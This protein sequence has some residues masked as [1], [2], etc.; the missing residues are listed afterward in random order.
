MFF[1]FTFPCNQKDLKMYR[2]AFV[3]NFHEA[4]PCGN[5]VVE[6]V[7]EAGNGWRNLR[8]LRQQ[9][10]VKITQNLCKRIDFRK[11]VMSRECDWNSLWAGEPYEKDKLSSDLSTP[12]LHLPTVGV[13]V[14]TLSCEV[15]VML[16]VWRRSYL[17]KEVGRGESTAN[18]WNRDVIPDRT[19]SLPALCGGPPK[20]LCLA[21]C[22]LCS[23]FLTAPHGLGVQTPFFLFPAHEGKQG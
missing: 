19:F 2:K 15:F 11:V 7:W 18:F 22:W 3:A 12:S 21:H 20:V 9:R 5:W 1:S 13:A 10:V 4:V 16:C 8:T 6:A 23:V 17:I 14:E